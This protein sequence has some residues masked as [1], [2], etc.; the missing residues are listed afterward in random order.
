MSPRAGRGDEVQAERAR[1]ALSTFDLG[2]RGEGPCE[3]AELHLLHLF[4]R[5]KAHEVR[6]FT[7][8]ALHQLL[9]APPRP[10]QLAPP[11]L[12]HKIKPTANTP[13]TPAVR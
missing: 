4:S 9:D 3:K 12:R 7:L 1:K 8:D 2:E 5:V 10:S 13:P 11:A 6:V